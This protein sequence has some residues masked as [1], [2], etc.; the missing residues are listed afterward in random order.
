MAHEPDVLNCRA[1]EIVWDA[2][3]ER[4]LIFWATTIPGRFPETDGQ[5]D[6]KYNH[7]M[8]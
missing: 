8:H 4:F 2:K 7:R 5:G 1:P 3:R 6:D